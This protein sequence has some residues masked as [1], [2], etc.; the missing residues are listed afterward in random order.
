MH[1]GEGADE[2]F[3]HY[4]LDEKINGFALNGGVYVVDLV[5]SGKNDH[6]DIAVLLVHPLRQLQPGYFEH[7]DIRQDCVDR[8]V[9]Q[10]GDRVGAVFQRGGDMKPKLVPVAIFGKAAARLLFVVDDDQLI[11]LSVHAQPS[12][13]YKNLKI[14]YHGSNAV[15]RRKILTTA[16]KNSP[17]SHVSNKLLNS[18]FPA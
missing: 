12:R 4:G 14:L 18:A 7:L 17:F 10:I 13:S 3:L 15:K 5:V 1:F 6:A 11:I 16:A 8:M 9:L 2:V